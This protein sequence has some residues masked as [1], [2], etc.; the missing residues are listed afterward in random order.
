MLR[1]LCRGPREEDISA[2][3]IYL[4]CFSAVASPTARIYLSCA[5][6]YTLEYLNSVANLRC[7]SAVSGLPQQR[8]Y[9]SAV[10]Q[11]LLFVHSEDKPQLCAAINAGT[12]IAGCCPHSWTLATLDV[13]SFALWS[14]LL[15]MSLMVL[16]SEFC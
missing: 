2:A 4:N 10:A 13:F 7:C 14:S 5:Q 15:A 8:G 16:N 3:R 11:L 9:T 1:C 6:R 12:A